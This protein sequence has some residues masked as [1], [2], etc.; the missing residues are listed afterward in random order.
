MFP[1]S[2]SFHF[3]V[4]PFTWF[5]GRHAVSLK[6]LLISPRK[7]RSGSI[8]WDFVGNQELA[9]SMRDWWFGLDW[10]LGGGS[11]STLYRSFVVSYPGLPNIPHPK[12]S[13][14]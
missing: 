11:P 3:K 8:Y 10:R 4:D 6:D 7:N 14:L 9:T 1:V 5:D 12:D 13:L 2:A